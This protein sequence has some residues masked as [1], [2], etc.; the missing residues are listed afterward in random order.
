MVCLSSSSLWPPGIA[1]NC[2]SSLSITT[3]CQSPMPWRE[4]HCQS[5]M[6]IG[7]PPPPC[8]H[9]LRIKVYLL[10]YI[11]QCPPHPLSNKYCPHCI[12]ISVRPTKGENGSQGTSEDQIHTMHHCMSVTQSIPLWTARDTEIYMAQPLELKVPQIH[13]TCLNVPY[14]QLIHHLSI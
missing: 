8:P 4:Q 11:D 1:Y 14:H 13:S 10:K 7:P 3:Y 5:C 6:H 2:K 9:L 12:I